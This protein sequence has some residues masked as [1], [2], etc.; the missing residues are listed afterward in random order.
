MITLA[1]DTVDWGS[2]P[3]WVSA[4]TPLI[5]AGI[6]TRALNRTT[7]TI[8]E[9]VRSTRPRTLRERLRAFTH[10]APRQDGDH[11][12]AGHHQ[13]PAHHGDHPDGPE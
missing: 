4:L 2:V 8:K 11:T 10:P 6:L 5:L 7:A 9:A 1:A 12:P 13:G 3:A